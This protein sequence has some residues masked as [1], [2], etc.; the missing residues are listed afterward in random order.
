MAEEKTKKGWLDRIK[1]VEWG[2]VI[3][4]EGTLSLGRVS[5]WIVF[6]MMLYMWHTGA[7]LPPTLVDAFYTLVVYNGGKKITG[8]LSAFF[9]EKMN[10]SKAKKEEP[11]QVEEEPK[12]VEEA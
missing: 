5:Y 6:G 7:V 12:Q 4:E 3:L 2:G 10:K 9:S 8:P 1:D 11:K